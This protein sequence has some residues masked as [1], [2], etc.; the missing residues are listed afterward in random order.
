MVRIQEVRGS[1]PLISTRKQKDAFTVSFCFISKPGKIWGFE[2][3]RREAPQASR[4]SADDNV[5][6]RK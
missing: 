5:S 3:E 1:T 6:H 2:G 4:E